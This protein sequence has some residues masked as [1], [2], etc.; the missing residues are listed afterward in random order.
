[1]ARD[2][3]YAYTI[4]QSVGIA[5][6]PNPV[7]SGARAVGMGG[8]FIA[9]ADD[10]TAASWNPAGLTQLETPE[11]SLVGDQAF[12]SEDFSSSSIAES[13]SS[14]HTE[15]LNLNYF[16]ISY[17]FHFL[18]KNM[19]VS[20]NY[21]RLYDFNRS[22]NYQSETSIPPPV[23]LT[24]TQSRSYEQNGYLS[25]L[26]LAYAVDITSAISL[27]VTFNI[28]TGQLGWQNGWEEN[29]SNH[30]VTT[31][32]LTKNI[33]DSHITEKYSN[34]RGVNL[35]LGFLWKLNQSL[36]VGAVLKTPFSARID[37]QYT[38]DWI[39]RDGNGNI[40]NSSH[41]SISDDIKLR[42][43]LSYGVGFAWRFSDQFTIDLDVY[44]TDWSKY[45]LT[46]GQGN[47][48]SPINALPESMSD[49]KD[50]TQIRVGGEYLFVFPEKN[51][52]IPLRVGFFY[53]PEP[54]QGEAKD[55]YGFSVGS[56]VAYKGF[57]FDV[58]YQLRWGR[59]LDT[60]NLIATSEADMMQH[61]IL[62]SLIIHF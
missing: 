51:M 21:Q 4:G 26:G 32:G 49:I 30:S 7:G 14:S 56:G 43:P 58:A 18:N 12:K 23:S 9:I 55:F 8:A 29:Y 16:S 17:P 45:V 20:L 53:D 47:K 13:N 3:L 38:D 50:T 54:S 36:T 59:N 28:W 46:D 24:N 60:G 25:A 41:T 44:R 2:I 6:S 40:R 11:I 19:V 10:A 62:A 61:T 48:M 37:H 31:M 27:G 15:E 34:F 39:Q 22:L 1:L 52:A 57:I 35:N 42:M 33:E 5:S